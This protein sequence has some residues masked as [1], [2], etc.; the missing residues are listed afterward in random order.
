MWVRSRRGVI[1]GQRLQHGRV[2]LL[3]S[4]YGRQV[5]EHGQR[6]PAAGPVTDGRGPAVGYW[7]AHPPEGPSSE[8]SLSLEAHREQH[9]PEPDRLMVVNTVDLSTGTDASNTPSGQPPFGNTEHDPAADAHGA[10]T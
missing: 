6:Q 7:R 2:L 5:G 9:S 1:S 3:P 4:S 10:S 8:R